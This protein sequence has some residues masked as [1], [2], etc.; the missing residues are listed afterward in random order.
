MF[1]NS[2]PMENVPEL[3]QVPDV[4]TEVDD[5]QEVKQTESNVNQSEL[6]AVNGSPKKPHFVQVKNRQVFD[7]EPNASS[8]HASL[9]PHWWL[10]AVHARHD[11]RKAEARK[12][13]RLKEGLRDLFQEALEVGTIFD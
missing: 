9:W 2:D 8:I 6:S 4:K 5:Q 10:R 12:N 7:Y 13:V 11:L 1:R 3:V